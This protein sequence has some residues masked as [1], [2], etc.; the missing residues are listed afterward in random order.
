MVSWEI[1]RVP[2]QQRR[3]LQDLLHNRQEHQPVVNDRSGK[4][5][6]TCWSH[7]RGGAGCMSGAARRDGLTPQEC[8]KTGCVCR[9]QCQ[10]AARGMSR[11]K[12]SPISNASEET[13]G[14]ESQGEGTHQWKS[15]ARNPP[16]DHSCQPGHLSEKAGQ[17]EV[18]S[19]G[20]PEF[21]ARIESEDPDGPGSS[22]NS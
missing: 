3:R 13:A 17:R 2:E 1:E 10:H 14:Q 8:A 7:P 11:H 12:E 18:C 19:S 21:P 4:R 16:H 22:P 9:W 20:E 5:E 6:T 15:G